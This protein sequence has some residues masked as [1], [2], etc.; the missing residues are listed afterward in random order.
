[1]T[2]IAGIKA[3]QYGG[4]GSWRSAVYGRFG[5]WMC[6]ENAAGRLYIEEG[7]T[8]LLYYGNDKTELIDQIEKEW[9]YNGQTVSGRPSAHTPFKL[10]VRKSN[11][12]I[13][14][15]LASG[16]TVTI[17]GKKKVTDAK[18]VTA[19][20]GLAPGVHVVTM[21]GYRN[22]TVPA[23]AKRLYYLTV[24]APERASFQD[25]A[26]VADWATDGMSNALWHGLIQGVSAQS[27]ILAPKKRWRAQNSR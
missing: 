14:G 13:G 4:Q 23:A 24:S 27:S 25:R 9:I 22:G 11:P 1:M 5:S 16:I 26:Q 19:W 21:T 15:L 7:G 12:A 3:G 6:E 8:L 20:N 2:S 10:T 18:G 17:D